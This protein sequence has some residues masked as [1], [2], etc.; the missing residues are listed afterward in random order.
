MCG[1]GGGLLNLSL[2]V[3]ETKIKKK[4]QCSETTDLGFKPAAHC[5]I[6]KA[7]SLHSVGFNL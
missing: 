3:S 4:K 2:K 5:G 6:I 1:G 7:T